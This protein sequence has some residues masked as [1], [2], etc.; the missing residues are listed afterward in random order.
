MVVYPPVDVYIAME[1]STIFYGKLTISMGHG[2]NSEL[3][4]YQRVPRYFLKCLG[5]IQENVGLLIPGLYIFKNAIVI[6]VDCQYF[7]VVGDHQ[8]L[9]I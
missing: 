9:I 4:A 5:E 6:V 3:L 8:W 7:T 2:F 1:R